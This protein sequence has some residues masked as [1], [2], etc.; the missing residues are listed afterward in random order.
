MRQRAQ[1]S[2]GLLLPLASRGADDTPSHARALCRQIDALHDPL[3]DN[4][5]QS[6]LESTAAAVGC[7]PNTD[8]CYGLDLPKSGDSHT[9][10][11]AAAC[12]ALCDATHSCAAFIY[13][14]DHC[15]LKS[16]VTATD[17][18]GATW[19]HPGSCMGKREGAPVP[20]AVGSFWEMSVV[21]QQ[22][23]TGKEQP[24][25]FRF[26]EVNSTATKS[27]APPAVIYFDSFTYIP[28]WCASDTLADCDTPS[29]YYS[30]MLDTHMFWKQ[31][32]AA[33]QRMEL[34]LPSR[35]EDTDGALLATQ[36]SYALVLDMITR[37]GHEMW[38]RYGTAPGYEQPGIGA[39]GAGFP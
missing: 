28:S 35:P 10:G 31:T 14:D 2:A 21:P 34:D 3:L 33:E 18:H 6:N 25:F 23:D 20:A 5:L 8:C 13:R 17:G 30:A 16:A 7:T 1:A 9:A 37:T 12:S 15:W 26:M 36:A 29:N 38:P 4:V 19:S 22:R 27:G 11:S 24:V 39:D 32:W